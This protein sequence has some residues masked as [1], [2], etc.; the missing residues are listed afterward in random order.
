MIARRGFVEQIMGLPISIHLRGHAEDTDGDPAR[1][2]VTAAFERLRAVDAV[3]STWRSDSDLE[4]VRSGELAASAAHPWLAEVEA[5]CAEAEKRTGGLFSAE[6]GAAGYDP[7]GLVKGWAVQAAAE[8]LARVPRI[9]YCLNAGGDLVAG[10]GP[11]ATPAPWRIGIENPRTRSRLATTVELIDGGLATSGTAARGAHIRDPRSGT[12]VQRP[13]SATVW[14][15]SLL[16][17]DVWATALF[18]DPQAGAAAL[19]AADPA[20]QQL[21][22]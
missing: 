1:A 8:E 5:L 21:I 2:A 14:G 19:A 22:L 4:R 10:A 15:P 11:G 18:V 6:V 12:P 13:G 9:E 7:T 16:W 3:F 17:A 20:Y